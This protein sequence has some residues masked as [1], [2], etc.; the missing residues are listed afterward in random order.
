MGSLQTWSV[1]VPNDWGMI[2]FSLL[3]ARSNTCFVYQIYYTSRWLVYRR[4]PSCY[5]I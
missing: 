3:L 4:M 5:M 1:S 2:V